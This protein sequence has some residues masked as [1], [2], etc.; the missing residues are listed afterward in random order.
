M[1]QNVQ[2][3]VGFFSDEGKEAVKAARNELWNK[4]NLQSILLD[5]AYWNEFNPIGFSVTGDNDLRQ[6]KSKKE[7]D[8]LDDETRHAIQCIAEQKSETI[9]GMVG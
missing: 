9:S 4:P 1:H 5:F 8:T 6:I 2:D 3:E 7:F